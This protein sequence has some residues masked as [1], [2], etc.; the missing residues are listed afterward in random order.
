MTPFSM[1]GSFAPWPHRVF[2]VLILLELIMRRWSRSGSLSS[3]SACAAAS[4]RRSRPPPARAAARCHRRPATC[5]RPPSATPR[6]FPRSDLCFR[7]CKSSDVV[8]SEAV[9]LALSACCRPIASELLH[10]RSW[11]SVQNAHHFS[12]NEHPD[13]IYTDVG[14]QRTDCSHC[15]YY[16]GS[17]SNYAPLAVASLSVS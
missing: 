12:R 2:E 3:P 4:H 17:V 11:T 14:G 15:P 10:P 13:G 1:R 7:G 6:A 8:S 5:W 16:S 9:L